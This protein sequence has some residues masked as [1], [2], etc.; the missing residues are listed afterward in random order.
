[1]IA[2]RPRKA[3]SPDWVTELRAAYT[4]PLLLLRD[5]G[6]MP[7]AVGYHPLAG[8]DFAFRVP[9]PYARR[10]R[11][12]DGA[13]PL[14][15]QVLPHF[16]ERA[17]AAGFS[18]DPVGDLAAAR[19]PGLLH[20]YHGRA[21]LLLSGAC[22]V[23]CRFCFRREFP[24]QGAVGSTQLAA[25]LRNIE[26]DSSVREVILSGG[27]PLLVHDDKLDE[28]ITR[29]SGI[30]HVRRLRI[31]SRL[32]LV[33]PAR[34]TPVLLS[35]LARTRLRTV[36]V[37][38]VNHAQE[39]DD[40]VVTA[41]AALARHGVTLLNQS[42][43]LRGVND[44]AQVLAALSEA[45]FAAHV[46]PYYLHLLDRVRGAAHFEVPDLAAR[47]LQKRLLALLPGYLVPRLVREVAGAPSKVPFI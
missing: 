35:I 10:M 36:L 5:L 18:A 6:L 38:H 20:K 12:G 25:A 21:L 13:D 24:Y 27:D 31:H 45:L 22:A 42:V 16:E 40:E 41:S 14:L 29:L 11:I 9:R 30:P 4:E 26:Q 8:R 37:L 7:A 15:R 19:Q 47:E 17:E 46:L 1:M 3:E 33:L 28:L 43:L 34:I 2:R 44:D 39:I 23:N 32:P